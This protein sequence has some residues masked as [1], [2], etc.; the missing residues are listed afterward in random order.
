MV[1]RRYLGD[2]FSFWEITFGVI[3]PMLVSAW[4]SATATDRKGHVRA[5]NVMKVAMVMAIGYAWLLGTILHG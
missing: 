1:Y 5:G 3:A 4:L 2:T